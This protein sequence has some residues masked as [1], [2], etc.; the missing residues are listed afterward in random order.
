MFTY[1]RSFLES[2]MYV[3]DQ[4]A[5]R[6]AGGDPLGRKAY[7]PLTQWQLGV[8]SADRWRAWYG[9]APVFFKAPFYAYLL[10][11]L[12]TVFGD[13]MLPVVVL[14]ILAAALSLLLI[15]RIGERLF[16]WGAGCAAALLFAC[17][18]PA[19]HYDAVMLRGPWVVLV[20]LLVTERLVALE[21]KPSGRTALALGIA[22]ALALLVNE[23][24]LAL[25]VLVL[26]TIAWWFRD[27]GRLAAVGGG[28]LLGLGAGLAPLIARNV[29][30]GAP[31][32]ALA[33]TG[34]MSFALCNTADASPYFFTIPPSL[35]TI[36]AESGGTLLAA[37]RACLESFE[38]P[39]QAALFYLRRASGLVAGFE[40]P[41]NDSFYYAALK[42]PVLGWLPGYGLAFP[43]G[44]VG[45]VLTARERARLAALLPVPLCLVGSMMLTLPLS[46]YR[47]ALAVYVVLL[48]GVA[49]A[50]TA[51]W[52]RVRRLRPLALAGGASLAIFLAGGALER[53]VVFGDRS[54]ATARYRPNDFAIGAQVYA[55]RG[56]Y[57][58]A[59]GEM[60]DLVRL[61]PHPSLV[62]GV[63]VKVEQ[64]GIPAK[65][66]AATREFFERAA[67]VRGDDPV[68][69]V[70]LGD[71]Y[72]RLL[73][74]RA[75]A[76]AAYERALALDPSPEFERSLQTRI[77][78]L[79][80][81]SANP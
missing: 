66:E 8:A 75:G 34:A 38:S 62:R 32:L 43:L 10:A 54:P 37:A 64:L 4:W 7:H 39:W 44:A 21:S 67:A 33:V 23:G 5:Q 63:F 81:I 36:L 46:R 70:A 25:P 79:K 65:D 69:L 52:L 30:V 45:L 42:D 68:F 15:L 31:P 56:R 78:P 47:I 50:R 22:V 72:R 16:G 71:A 18:G 77:D 61:N 48:A 1:H 27:R 26:A 19:I 35:A 24:F 17:Y 57:R 73:R 12:H 58:E 41:Q 6:I 3:F 11:V 60:L 74:D 14:Q 76:L 80:S 28:F 9:E 59:L 49:L 53:R 13:A 55:E 29:L 40:N 2:D 51:R 20:S